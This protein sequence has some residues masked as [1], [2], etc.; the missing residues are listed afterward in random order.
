MEI[1]IIAPFKGFQGGKAL[2]LTERIYV[3]HPQ[4]L[5]VN[6]SAGVSVQDE[7]VVGEGL[8]NQLKAELDLPQLA[9]C[10][11]LDKVTSGLLLLARTSEANRL[12][13]AQ[14]QARQTEK[15]YLAIAKGKPLKK[16]GLV[17]GDMQRSRRGSWQLLRSRNNPAVTQFFS[18][19]LG[20][21]YR[22]YLLKPL[23][24][25]THQ[26][27]VMMKS[28][29]CP[30]LGDQRYGGAAADRTYL[31]AYSLQF[32]WQ[33]QRICHQLLP[34][35]GQQ[36]PE[37]LPEQWQQPDKLSWPTLPTQEHNKNKGD[38]C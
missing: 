11:R 3:E 1:R 33:Q 19:A 8:L 4:W 37:A 24:G 34:D 12:L 18:H 21:G 22:L 10:H 36:W 7:T 38:A 28:L 27:R 29:G 2:Q 9:L 25:K 13:S 17:I 6:K 16:Q 14:F 15:Y 26:L 35:M 20:G 23:T 31:H 5:L 32:N 30:I